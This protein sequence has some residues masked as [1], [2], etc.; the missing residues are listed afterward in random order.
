MPHNSIQCH[1]SSVSGAGEGVL[2]RFFV[3]KSDLSSLHNKHHVVDHQCFLK[4]NQQ[5]PSLNVEYPPGNKNSLWVF[6]RAL[7]KNRLNAVDR[8]GPD[9]AKTVNAAF[10]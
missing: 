10:A 4:Y 7:R 1:W 6:K 9:T 3:N 5:Q 8:H 2:K